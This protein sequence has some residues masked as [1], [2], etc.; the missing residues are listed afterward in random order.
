[1]KRAKIFT[2]LAALL[3]ATTSFAWDGDGSGSNPWQIAS[4]SDWNELANQVNNKN[5]NYDGKYFLLT[6]DISVSTMIGKNSYYNYFSANFDGGGHTLTVNYD[7]SS[8]Y[9]APFRMVNCA[10]I[11]HLH[12]AGT[13]KTSAKYAGGV[14]GYAI[15]HED[16]HPVDPS[17]PH[18]ST[19]EDCRVSVTITSTVNGYGEHGGLVA[20]NKQEVLNIKG[21][22]FDGSILGLETTNCGGFV[23][24]SD[25]DY[26]WSALHINNS[27]FM[28]TEVD[29]MTGAETF[30]R[31]S[32]GASVSNSYYTSI[33]G[34]AQGKER[35]SI[36]DGQGMMMTMAGDPTIYK[37]SG[38][39]AYSDNAG[40]TY[41]GV[42]YG[43]Q[44][45]QVK[46]NFLGASAYK[47][48][49]GTLSGD[50]PYIL[51]MADGDAVV[52]VASPTTSTIVYNEKE[53]RDA[54]AD[55]AYIQLGRDIKIASE[56]GIDG[57]KTVYLDL[58]GHRLNRGLLYRSTYGFVLKNT[59]GSILTILD[60]SGDNSG[61]IEGGYTGNGGGIYNEAT[62][63]FSSGTIKN[64]HSS[65]SGGGINN[66][67]GA[68]AYI[69]G[70]VITANAA[71]MNGGGIYNE[72]SLYICGKVNVTGNR[73]ESGFADNVYLKEGTVINMV[74]NL[75]GSTI[76]IDMETP[77]VFTDGYVFTDKE[78]VTSIFSADHSDFKEVDIDHGNGLLTGI[79]Y[80][81]KIEYVVREWDDTNKRLKSTVMIADDPVVLNSSGGATLTK[82]LY[83]VKG[84]VTVDGNILINPEDGES[85]GIILCDG[86]TLETKYKILFHESTTK[87]KLHIYG[88]ENNTGK[89]DMSAAPE[90]TLAPRIGN[91]YYENHDT[92]GEVNIHGGTFVMTGE[93]LNP[94]IGSFT[95]SDDYEESSKTFYAKSGVIN[96]FGGIIKATGGTGAAAI[97]SG[98]LNHDYGTINI[99][100]GDITAQGGDDTAVEYSGGAAIGGGQYITGGN[101]NIY[102]G[103][104]NA[105]GGPEAAGIGGGE[106]NS[107][108]YDTDNGPG[109]IIIYGGTVIAHGS[110]HAA[111]IGYGDGVSGKC[112]ITISGGHVEAYGGTDAAGI[113]GGEGGP[114]GN[115][116]ITGGYVV[117]NGNDYGAGI[118]GGQDGE[119]GN[120]S[121][122][123]G[124]V[125]AKAGR[126]ETGWRAIG[127][128]SG[129]DDYGKLTVGNKMMVSSERMAVAAER[130]DMCWYRTQARLDPCTHQDATYVISGT[131]EED[132]HTMQ[133]LY[134][135]MEFI[136]ER[137]QFVDG[138]CV[139][140]GT[141]GTA[142]EVSIYLPQIGG[143]DGSYNPP[144]NHL[145]ADGTKYTLPDAPDDHTPQGLEFAG[146]L[147]ATPEHLATYVADP[148]EELL[149][150]GTAYTVTTS[151]SFTA[152]YK[153]A[154]VILSDTE[155]NSATIHKYDGKKV[156]SV[157]LKGRTFYK[158]GEWNT[159]CLPFAVYNLTG[160][161]LE[162]A[163]LMTLGN[164]S[165]CN[166]GFNPETG[167]LSLDFVSAGSIEPGVAYIVKWETS[168]S[169]IEDPVFENVTISNEFPG[170]Q[171][172]TSMDGT[173][174]F[175][176]TYNPRHI[177]DEDRKTLYMGADNTLYYPNG[178]M[179][180]NAFRSFFR[181]IGITAGDGSGEVRSF[182]LN[183]GDGATGMGEL[184][185]GR[186][187][188]LKLDGAW[189]DL[190]GR[191]VA[192]SSR[193][194]LLAP[195]SLRKGIYI[196]NGKKV[197]IK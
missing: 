51:T 20:Y 47:T 34:E 179:T 111:G 120:I 48:S 70:G 118:G 54:I 157:T 41:N 160:T 73:S 183:F 197:V 38:I 138:K 55:G 43:G 65:G 7:T 143:S 170:D 188:G 93:E 96:I 182:N 136:P 95:E 184:K 114:G 145:V 134:C 150:V 25:K 22:V 121:I 175:Y 190:S 153:K 45:D 154:N 171:G 10:H 90:G 33:F 98:Y 131:T 44:G 156:S 176:G 112:N 12:V 84:K 64:N 49:S 158:T 185:N 85:V 18:T 68:T 151:V 36:T 40:L 187:E 62:L 189:Y 152:R 92:E 74:N 127:P 11:R 32:E 101:L 39:T 191:K 75:A 31:A 52:S 87:A 166:T 110:T 35:H 102:G 97:G 128:G 14:I 119:G 5:M 50:N 169:D 116:I 107:W 155:H 180:I 159:L 88:Q 58:N 23:G 174:T 181:L 162:G 71:G 173:V 8:D 83:V 106:G 13:I 42:V 137:H 29:Q 61:C 82:K 144:V 115:I 135:T 79:D 16:V 193:S 3:C 163:T 94:C 132:T 59:D 178:D 1:M 66:T 9:T 124:T 53:L 165:G 86:A 141:E 167:V 122:T 196:I 26:S 139:V 194:S 125:I 99:Y 6:N 161:P 109:T 129:S 133:C 195:H 81:D 60:S 27:L 77:D 80:G 89:I 146:W 148:S 126:D 147:V 100:G 46:L 72:G 19:I 164:S 113:G 103:T 2:L 17:N 108:E 21:C 30:Y 57:G 123:G 78:Q 117:A 69:L 142:F 24:R 186:M 4:E 63:I 140:C 168:D 67:A 149:P 130:H 56:I 37:V 91:M 104:I 28:P 177:Y 192:D 15:N 105:T 76:G 172:T